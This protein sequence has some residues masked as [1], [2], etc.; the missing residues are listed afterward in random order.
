MPRHRRTP[1]QGQ[2]R[3]D[4]RLYEPLLFGGR[5]SDSQ[6]QRRHRDHRP[7]RRIRQPKE[8][9]H[10]MSDDKPA[11]NKAFKALRRTLKPMN[12]TK[13]L[14]KADVSESTLAY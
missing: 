12:T 14:A 6:P 4:R 8:G 13:D 5:R 3:E 10:G 11:D 2:G 9:K 1:T 7:M